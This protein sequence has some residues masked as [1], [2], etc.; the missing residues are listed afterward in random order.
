MIVKSSPYYIPADLTQQKLVTNQS[1]GTIYYKATSDVDA[2]DTAVTVG[3]SVTLTAGAFFIS[4][5]TS[6]V[7]VDDVDSPTFEDATIKDDL[8]VKGTLTT[9][10]G[11]APISAGLGA[12]TWQAPTAESGTD[13]AF[14]EKK[15]FTAS[16]FLPC[17]TTL[18][19]VK[20]LLG[21]GGG[22]NKVIAALFDSAGKKVANS[23]ETTEGTTAGTEKTVQTLAFT[24]TYAAKGPARY[25]IGITANGNTAKL[26]TIPANTALNGV[27][28]AEI[29][30]ETKNVV[31]ASITAPTEWIAAKGPVA[32]VY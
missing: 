32:G 27:L 29:S 18:T 25:F 15:L 21:A 16:I 5:S 24:S 12:V 3:N 14:A 10:E 2:E 7:R 26:R 28:T 31:P 6:K 30:L 11:I 22:T 20:Y 9:V 23:S 4:A 13:T 8:E 1:G 19:G 17:N